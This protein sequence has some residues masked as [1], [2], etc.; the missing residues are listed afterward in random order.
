MKKSLIAAMSMIS[1]SYANT[2]DN[3]NAK[4]N[5]IMK[6]DHITGVAIALVSGDKVEF[7][8]YG[9]TN[10]DHQTA[11]TD[12]SIFEIAS[13]TK[14][15][16]AQIAGITA[17]QHKIDIDSPITKY[18]PEL[19]ANKI[20]NNINTKELLTHVAGLPMKFDK[21][22][23]ES[24]LI[25]SAIKYKPTN[26]PQSYYQYS[27]IGITLS[28]IALTRIYNTDY[29]SLLNKLIL[30]PL[31]MRFTTMDISHTNKRQLV[32]GYDKD[33]KQVEYLNMG[34][35][36]SAGGLKSNTYD[37]AKYLQFQINSNESQALAAL[38]IIHS[39]YYCLYPNGSSQQL[40]W[41][42]HPMSV[43]NDKFQPDKNYRN[44]IEPHE[45][46]KTCQKSSIG[47][48]D[49]TG[50]SSGMS[51]YMGY[52]PTDKTGVVI[53]SNKALQPDIVNLGRYILKNST[54]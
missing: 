27:N 15:F 6:K 41:E 9:Y 13:L 40:A 18:I 1:L 45:L 19:S 26:K 36:S 43:L 49:K 12:K 50:N 30:T 48:I 5:K 2:C 54:K 4:A 46:P 37:L 7:C 3:I 32:T 17:N 22:Y 34:I 20:Y 28:A 39:N 51:S 33:N 53:L 8:N 44:L 23:T 42:Y 11:I 38:K 31:E 29:Q 21:D 47:F 35:K 14:T 52:I 24:E 16:T 25:S 10:K